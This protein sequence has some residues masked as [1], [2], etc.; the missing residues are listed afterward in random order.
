MSHTSPVLRP[1]PQRIKDDLY[2]RHLNSL[3]NLKNKKYEQVKEQPVQ[4]KKPYLQDVRTYLRPLSTPTLTDAKI[5][6]DVLDAINAAQLLY[7]KNQNLNMLFDLR[8]RQIQRKN[9][10]L[11]NSLAM[12]HA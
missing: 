12:R 3:H 7:N 9:D 5:K 10:E 2:N 4:Q 11:K 8:K 1:M 6:Q